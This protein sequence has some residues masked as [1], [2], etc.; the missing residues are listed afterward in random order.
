MSFP[1]VL[2][3][4][5]TVQKWRQKQRKWRVFLGLKRQATKPWLLV[6][7]SK[8][9]TDTALL[10]KQNLVKSSGYTYVRGKDREKYLGLP[11]KS[12]NSWPTAIALHL[13]DVMWFRTAVAQ[14]R[15]CPAPCCHTSWWQLC[16]ST[17]QLG[18]AELSR[19]GLKARL[20]CQ[21]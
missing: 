7:C 18:S 5:D 20:E 14:C 1:S 19:C 13:Y 16:P 17:S 11:W 6:L 3:S 9:Y 4:I 12:P 2:V 10:G 15:P 21:C 8:M